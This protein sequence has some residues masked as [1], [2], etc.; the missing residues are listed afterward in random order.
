LFEHPLLD[1]TWSVFAAGEPGANPHVHRRHVDAF[2]V[3]EGELQFG[4]GP[5]LEPLRASAGTFVLV[6][7]GVVHAFDNA[8]DATARWLNFHAPSTGFLAYLRGERGGFDSEDPP[9]DGGRRAANA[10]V[11]LAGDGERERQATST[12]GSEPQL[13]AT[14]LVLEPGCAAEARHG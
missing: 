12:L 3:V 4:V 11:T 14:L 5:D 8:S 13:V 2:Y 6:P 9:A 7:P 1:A 10:V